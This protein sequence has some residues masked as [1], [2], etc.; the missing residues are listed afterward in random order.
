MLSRIFKIC[1]GFSLLAP[2][3]SPALAGAAITSCNVSISPSTIPQ[4]ATSTLTFAIQ[5]TSSSAIVYV[6]IAAP[7]TGFEIIHANASGWTGTIP[8]PILVTYT[9]GSISAGGSG[10][11]NMVVLSSV[12]QV[13]AS[14]WTV[15]VSDD[16]NGGNA[17]SCGSGSVG[18]SSGS[19]LPVISNVAASSIGTSEATVTYSTDVP[20]DTVVSF[21]Q[22]Q[23]YGTTLPDSAMVAS[24]SMTIFGLSPDTVYH[25]KVKSANSYGQSSESSDN[26]FVTTRPAAPSS[27]QTSTPIVGPSSALQIPQPESSGTGVSKRNGEAKHRPALVFDNTPPVITLST[28]FSLPFQSPPKI[29]G[30]ATDEGGV[31]RLQYSVDDGKNWLPIKIVKSIASGTEFTFEPRIVQEGNYLVRVSAEDLRKNRTVTQAFVLIIDRLSPQIGGF[32]TSIGP[33][34]VPSMEN[35]EILAVAGL[36]ERI[37]L[38]VLG[39]ATSVDLSS[40]GKTFSLSKS[41]NTGLWTGALSFDEPG[42][43]PLTAMAVDG[44]KRLVR[45]DLGQVLVLDNGKVTYRGEA[46]GGA[47]VTLFMFEPVLKRFVVWDGG[48][49]LQDNPKVTDSGGEY[50][51]IVPPGK[52]FLE[53]KASGFQ[54]LRTRQFI[55]EKSMPLKVDLPLEKQYGII[56]FFRMKLAVDLNYASGKPELGSAGHLAGRTLPEFSFQGAAGKI[57]NKQF[58]GKP[59]VVTLL[60][61]WS[62]PGVEQIR[63]LDSLTLVSAINVVAILPQ[64]TPFAREILRKRGGFQTSMLAD[65]EGLS[66]DM[67]G[68]KTSPTHFF[69]SKEGLVTRVITGVLSK[70]DLLKNLVN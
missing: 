52:Y 46:V 20:S 69:A 26:T 7:E 70:E 29:Q 59:T 8:S 16:P 3:L 38:S 9:G 68:F 27:S 19:S 51:F 66:I 11:I 14:N 67:F 22:S 6:N 57:S 53:V 64:E 15:R 45:K 13:E 47:L 40:E 2:L 21:G 44:A 25:Y 4:N 43:F 37:T 65:P 63:I 62:P 30:I 35:G 31:Y 42:F 36:D 12:N 48:P 32:F 1:L 49:F 10:D 56:P 28:D 34:A 58:V 50:S 18:V 54:K 55:V 24:H 17:F 39:G 41:E 5:N 61:T 60:N 33:Q 23:S